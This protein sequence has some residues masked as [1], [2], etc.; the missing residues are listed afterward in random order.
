MSTFR[1]GDLVVTND[2]YFAIVTTDHCVQLSNGCEE[3]LD[4]TCW[5][6]LRPVPINSLHEGTGNANFQEIMR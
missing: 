3:V 1:R 5:N 2:G 6:Q 4:E